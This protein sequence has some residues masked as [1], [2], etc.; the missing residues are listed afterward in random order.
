MDIFKYSVNVFPI[1]KN[2][3]LFLEYVFVIWILYLRLN[4]F[5]FHSY[6][7]AIMRLGSVNLQI[8]PPPPLPHHHRKPMYR[9]Y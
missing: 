9:Y 5:R 1:K 7:K 3:S 8:L 6:F 4:D 2:N